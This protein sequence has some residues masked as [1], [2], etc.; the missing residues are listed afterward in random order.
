MNQVSEAPVP[1]ALQQATAA[2]ALALADPAMNAEIQIFSVANG[3]SAAGLHL[4]SKVSL[5]VVKFPEVPTYLAGPVNSD[6]FNP[7]PLIDSPIWAPWA[8]MWR[9]HSAVMELYLEDAAGKRYLFHTFTVQQINGVPGPKTAEGDLQVPEGL[10]AIG[11]VNMSSQFLIDMP[12]LYNASNTPGMGDGIEIHGT[13]VSVGCLAMGNLGIAQIAAL[14]PS[15]ALIEPFQIS[16]GK[17]LNLFLN[18]TTPQ[19]E[20]AWGKRMSANPDF[21]AYNNLSTFWHELREQ[22]AQFMSK[23]VSG[24]QSTNN[25]L[26]IDCD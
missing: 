26:D 24:T 14:A 10:Y 9:E 18:Q 15:S 22:D 19:T 20:E 23:V 6:F 7:V 16:D 21:S 3:L 12:V 11:P 5:R 25:L 13:G 8:A 2:A 1:A 4:G 17:A